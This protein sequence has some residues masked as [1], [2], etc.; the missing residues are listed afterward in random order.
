MN[1]KGF[2]K[3]GADKHFTTLTHKDGH[4]I[5]L[6]H[7]S[8]SPSMREGLSKLDDAFSGENR[9]PKPNREPT[10]ATGGKVQKFANGGNPISSSTQDSPEQIASDVQ[11]QKSPVQI[12]VGNSPQPQQ[13]SVPQPPAPT[14]PPQQPEQH[15]NYSFVPGQAEDA[16]NKSL[17]VFN[18]AALE[19]QNQV[20]AERGLPP[21]STQ[22]K[23]DPSDEAAKNVFTGQVP[24]QPNTT[25][26]SAP[27]ISNETPSPPLPTASQQQAEETLPPQSHVPPPTP[28]VNALTLQQ[29]NPADPK[30]VESAA[31]AQE[32][33]A[34]EHDLNNGHITPKT[35]SSLFA[36][37]N[38][39][40]KIGTIFGMLLSGTGGA[41]AGQ[42]SM[43]LAM[44]DKQIEQDLQAQMKSKDNAQNYIRLNQQHLANQAS[45]KNLNV[46]TAQKAY[47]LAQGQM[48]QS[49]YHKMV[50]DFNKMP[51]GPSKEVARQNLGIVYSGIKDRINN[52]NDQASGAGAFYHTLFGDST[53]QPQNSEEAFQRQQSGRKALGPEG[54]NRAQ[55]AEAKHI[56]GVPGL[57]SRP[58]PEGIRSEITAMDT[59]DNRGSD[60]MN[61]I[62]QHPG[63]WHNE[64]EKAQAL[65]KVEEM[66]NFYNGSI[67]GGALTEGRLG[68]YDKQFSDK[69]LNI[70]HQMLGS[71][72]KFQEMINSNSAR[73]NIQLEKLGFTGRGSPQEPS[74]SGQ[75]PQI[76]TRTDPKTG[77]VYKRGPNGEAIRI[78]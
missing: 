13:P 48:L 44:M 75:Q 11:G 30:Q 7:A 38:T 60:L 28:H 32:N 4:E 19:H 9:Q 77:F 62:K 29:Y 65:Q 49:S 25:P 55:D 31:M 74:N 46:D 18:Q 69:P 21:L 6:A 36:D 16:A 20:R 58:I 56:P 70:L 50:D 61:F 35:Y 72:E 68:W 10:Y 43:A 24:S 2:K 34:W 45:I 3:K 59:L 37:R 67:K 17:E 39:I 8:L 47:A 15:G 22:D 63:L 52:I 1:F 64:K 51:E 33:A 27:P 76:E 14:P 23:M 78:K 41:I 57:A 73:K 66:K 54:V 40:G 71:N 5:K 42:P 53:S 12:F 26:Q